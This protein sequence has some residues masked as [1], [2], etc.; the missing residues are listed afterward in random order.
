MK[1][2]KVTVLSSIVTF[3]LLAMDLGSYMSKISTSDPVIIEKKKQFNSV[4]ETLEIAQGDMFLPSIDFS[5]SINHIKTTYKEPTNTISKSTNRYLTLS[6]TENLF[7][8]FGTINDI[9]AKKAS[10]A[11][12]AYSY[13]QTIN[14]ELLRAAKSY[15]DLARNKELLQ[16]E[17]DN[18]KKHKKIMYGIRTRH[19]AG[20]GTIGDLQEI[21]AKTNLAYSNYI[22]QLNNLQASQIAVKKF[23]GQPIDINFISLPDVGYSI[24]YSTD[25]A[26]KFAFSHNPSLFIQKYNI[27]VARYNQKRDKKEFLP[28]VDLTMSHSDVKQR[29]DDNQIDSK[30]KQVSGGISLKWNL[31]RGFKD[32][33]QEHKNISLIH[34]EYQ[35]YRALRRALAE[36]VELAIITYKMKQKEYIYLTRYLQN[37]QAKLNTITTL[38]RNGQKSLFEFLA[39]QTDYNSAKEKLINTKYDLIFTKFKVLKALGILSDMVNPALKTEV[40]INGNSLYEYKMLNY[41]ADRLPLVE[42]NTIPAPVFNTR[43]GNMVTDNEL[44]SYAI[45][46]NNYSQKSQRKIIKQEQP[47]RRVIIYDDAQPENDEV[48]KEVYDEEYVAPMR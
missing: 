20:V 16:V 7:N 18:Y 33:H 36:E 24:A 15:I 25:E 8:G 14:E 43:V 21:K 5:A 40:G 48:Y 17:I 26:I 19:R 39:S 35:K 10:L 2:V 28:T 9:E 42:D 31:F 38:F 22:T 3:N 37:A 46:N 47:K 12:M 45:V 27:I 6:L 32:L 1:I 4:Y 34:Q 13:I 30:Y 23:Y 29:D 41:K 11:S 44:N